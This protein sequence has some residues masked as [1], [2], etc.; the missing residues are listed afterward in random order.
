MLKHVLVPLDE[1]EGTSH[2]SKTAAQIAAGYGAQITGL[3][4]RD[5]CSIGG[6]GGLVTPQTPE[7]RAT[8]ERQARVLEAFRSTVESARLEFRCDIECGDAP[9][10]IA[11]AASVADLVVMAPPGGK[12]DVVESLVKNLSHPCIAVRE[13]VIEIGRVAVAYDGSRGASRA[14]SVAAD[15]V[16]NWKIGKLE[17]VL[18]SCSAADT[19]AANSA[20][21]YLDVY[22]IEPR[23]VELSGKPAEALVEGADTENADLLCIGAFG[24]WSMRSALL[25]SVTRTVLQKRA[26]PTLLCS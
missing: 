2:A 16:H 17:L 13:S 9:D 5:T 22:G 21:L 6:H 3:Y 10:E 14:L 25:G 23:I 19:E 12:L 8:G 15:L 1:T 11:R 18:L 20:K 4:V 24:S 7:E 26:K